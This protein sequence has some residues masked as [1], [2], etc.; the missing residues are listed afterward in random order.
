MA[1]AEA[2]LPRWLTAMEQ[3]PSIGEEIT[4]AM[5][6]ATQRAS[7]SDA[8][9]KGF[10]G[11]IVA[12]RQ[13]AH[14][15]DPLATR[16]LQLGSDYASELVNIDPGILRLIRAAEGETSGDDEALASYCELFRS[17]REAAQGTRAMVETV[18]E[19]LPELQSLHGL[20]RDLRPQSKK[21]EDGLRRIVDAQVVIDE[22]VR[23]IDE[24][25]VDCS[26]IPAGS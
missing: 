12:V 19:L 16:L 4:A 21:M 8:R 14:E 3:L 6:R 15:L 1:Q 13:L 9:G 17:I 24:S 5:N 22:W 25:E 20:S 7:E 26:G 2:A 23:V 11:R 10:A 18:E